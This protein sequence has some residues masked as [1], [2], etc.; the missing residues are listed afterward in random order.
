MA[1]PSMDRVVI[2]NVQPGIEGGRLPIKRVTGEP[3]V[4]EADIYTEGPEPVAAVLKY[5]RSEEATWQEVPMVPLGDD[6]WQATISAGAPGLYAYTVEA[7]LDHR[8]PEAEGAGPGLSG[9]PFSTRSAGALPLLVDPRLA[10]SGAWYEV[11]PRSCSDEPGRHGT[12][13][14]VER[15]L[16]GIAVLGF[17]V[18]YVPPIHPIGR[19]SRKGKNNCL[20]AGPDEPGSPWAVGAA[21]G[22]H[23]SVHPQLGDLADFR[24]MLSHARGLGLEVAL[25]IALQC[26]PDHPYVCEH[27]DWF[28][29]TPDGS[30]RTGSDSENR[31]EDI[32]L[33]DFHCQ[34]RA[35]L[36]EELHSIFAFWMEQGVRV[37]RVDNPHTKPFAFW[38]W[39]L[40][41]LRAA[42]PQTIFLSE[43]LTR[44][45]PMHRLAKVGF[46]LAHDYFPWRNTKAEL[47]DYYGTLMCGEAREYFRPVLWTNTA[48]CLP[49][50]LQQGTRAAFLTRLILAATLGA[51]YGIYGPAFELCLAE[52]QEPGTEIYK[53]SE[54]YELKVW[55]WAASGGIRSAIQRINH[56]R[57]ENPALQS[58]ASLRFH[59]VDNSQLI[60]YS[61]TNGDVSN[62]ILTVVNLDPHCSQHGWVSL[63]MECLGLTAGEAFRVDDLLNGTFYRWEGPRNYVELG[64][65]LTQAHVFRITR[66]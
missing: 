50:Y 64:P 37:F 41:R 63:D 18:V 47:E 30:F 44:P 13:R 28:Q 39:L 43:G 20:Q 51:S 29:R 5:R 7:W 11:F 23:K 9:R 1:V 65:T 2:G 46:N 26:S 21:E 8:R 53:D 19:T 62:A 49:V 40:P 25:D 3:L 57:R 4:V 31:Y 55:D 35:G 24:H 12:F 61:K 14:D 56:I 10:G 59:A 36:W 48:Q 15:R 58:N 52:P 6:R 17:D 60:A 27:P 16:D 22:G 32:I 34:D 66:E 54:Q 33:F 42:D 38:E 45:K